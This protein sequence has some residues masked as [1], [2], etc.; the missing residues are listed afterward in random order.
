MSALGATSLMVLVPCVV[1]L[2]RVIRVVVIVRAAKSLV[3]DCDPDQRAD[4]SARLV[5][6]LA[7]GPGPSRRRTVAFGEERD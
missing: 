4:L 6:V 3:E 5:S 7:A 2:T 1:V